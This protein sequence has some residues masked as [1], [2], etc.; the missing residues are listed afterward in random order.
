VITSLFLV[1]IYFQQL[2]LCVLLYAWEGKLEAFSAASF[3]VC[4]AVCPSFVAF[5]LVKAATAD[6]EV[7]GHRDPNTSPI[8]ER[9][10]IYVDGHRAPH[11]VPSM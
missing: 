10:H 5:G 7:V 6:D 4:P 1:L 11:R 8:E 3:C 2:F 9:K